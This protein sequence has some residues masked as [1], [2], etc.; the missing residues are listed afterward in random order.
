M[1][2]T[3]K[4]II[5]VAPLGSF[6]GKDMN[7]NIPIQPEEIAEEVYRAWNEGASVVHIHARDKNGIATTDPEVF[8]RIDQRIREKGCDIIIEHSTSPGREPGARV[9]DGI[10]S[11]D[12]QPEMASVDIGVQVVMRRG[13]E[14]INMWTRS[15][16]DRLLKATLEKGIKPELEI[17]TP[18]GMEEVN[19]HIETGLLKK[20]YWIDFVLDM[21]RTQQNTIR[22]T[23]KNLMH[24]VDLLPPDSMFLAMGIAGT[25]L[26]AAIQ[27]IL[28]GGH[29]RVG[30]EDNLMYR[31]GVLAESNAQLVVRVVSIARELGRNPASP[32]E[33]R[34]LLGIPKLQK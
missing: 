13:Q 19:V 24:Y 8:K 16:I 15:F 28:L 27:S 1:I 23:P 11:L 9:E 5:C 34:D 2:T 14:L 7:P 29:V 32:N 31:R 6:M 33:A 22:Y 20:P 4:L 21:Q 17:F 30:F 18:G 10:R 12:A 25:E 26:P 3:D